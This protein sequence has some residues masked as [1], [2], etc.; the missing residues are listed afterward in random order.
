MAS[1]GG[2]GLTIIEL[3]VVMAILGIIMGA[4]TY[5]GLSVGKEPYRRKAMADIDRITLA[6]EKYNL[7]F[8]ELP[9]DTGYG[10]R[11]EGDRPVWQRQ[12]NATTW[13]SVPTYDPGS[14]WRHLVKPVYDP[15]KSRTVGPFL[16]G[17][18]QSQLRRYNDI[19]YGQSFYLADPWGNPYGYIGDPRR[20][21]H[22]K[23]SFDVF[24]AG[25][26]GKTACNNEENDP[27]VDGKKDGWTDAS[28][29]PILAAYPKDNVAYNTFTKDGKLQEYDDDND[30]TPNN[31]TEFGPEA[32]RNGDIG[33]DVNNWTGR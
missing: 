31:S 25:N 32:V 16:T 19:F 11:M 10:L 28:D 14:L 7:Q 24:S 26:D 17:W 21:I 12:V 27:G 9:P 13:V 18:D 23:S 2:R 5:V 1:R 29:D 8:Q 20:R 6:L 15:E 3:L 30:G 4:L 33:D 22:N